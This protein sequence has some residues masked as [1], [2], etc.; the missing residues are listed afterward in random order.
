MHVSACTYS[1]FLSFFFLS[2]RVTQVHTYIEKRKSIRLPDYYVINN[3]CGETSGNSN[4]VELSTTRTWKCTR[5]AGASRADRQS[6]GRRSRRPTTPKEN[7]RSSVVTVNRT[8]FKVSAVG[9]SNS[10]CRQRRRIRDVVLNAIEKRAGAVAR[11]N[12]KY[13]QNR[14]ISCSSRNPPGVVENQPWNE[15]IKPSP[16]RGDLRTQQQQKRL[17]ATPLGLSCC[18]RGTVW[19]RVKTPRTKK[20]KVN[21]KYFRALVRLD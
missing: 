15:I 4:A 5:L 14:P 10:N 16:V 19:F 21:L 17:A 1:F 2:I 11:P 8:V 13:K 18:T 12:T 7:V 20:I 9:G 3:V 6:V